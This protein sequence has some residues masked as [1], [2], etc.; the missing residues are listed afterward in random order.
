[1]FIW[2]RILA[3]I[4]VR[5][6]PITSRKVPSPNGGHREIEEWAAGR[7]RHSITATAE[8]AADLSSTSWTLPY[9][10]SPLLNSKNLNA[11][12]VRSAGRFTKSNNSSGTWTSAN[13]WTP[14]TK[15]VS[16]SKKLSILW[17]SSKGKVFPNANGNKRRSKDNLFSQFT[18]KITITTNLSQSSWIKVLSELDPRPPRRLWFSWTG[19]RGMD[20]VP[21]TFIESPVWADW[22]YLLHLFIFIRMATKEKEGHQK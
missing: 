5:L 17:T 8:S 19:K 18:T 16:S 15:S 3:W 1:M 12:S 22:W 10:Q 9:L 21:T 14:S 13:K 11:C 20:T 4:R 7:P 6:S 2:N